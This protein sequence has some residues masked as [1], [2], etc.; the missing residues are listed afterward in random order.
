MRYTGT[1]SNRQQAQRQVALKVII[2]A[3]S[4][5]SNP[6]AM[7]R[8]AKTAVQIQHIDSGTASRAEQLRDIINALTV[9]HKDVEELEDMKQLVCYVSSRKA[10]QAQR[11]KRQAERSREFIQAAARAAQT[12]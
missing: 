3:A 2:T 6:Y 9:D 12:A 10:R 7:E 1:Y 8:L 5:I 11:A 4:K